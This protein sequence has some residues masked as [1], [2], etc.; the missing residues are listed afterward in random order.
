MEQDTRVTTPQHAPSAAPTLKGGLSSFEKLRD[1]EVKNAEVAALAT[2]HI[3]NFRRYTLLV[4][5]CIAQFL[6]TFNNSS[7]WPAMWVLCSNFNFPFYSVLRLL[8][9]PDQRAF[10]HD[11]ERL[12]MA[13]QCFSANIRKLFAHEWTHQRCV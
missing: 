12:Y 1:S 11:R 10:E 3:S 6:D 8:Q 13:Y 7:L 4:V 5:F 9:S 2:E